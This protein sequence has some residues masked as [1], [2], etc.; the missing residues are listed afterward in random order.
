MASPRNQ[1]CANRIGTFSFRT[2][3][4]YFRR[5]AKY[6]HQRVCVSVF[7]YLKHDLPKLCEIFCIMSTARLSPSLA[8]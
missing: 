2:A 3:G 8:I 6:H 5:G 1:H 7:A 4:I